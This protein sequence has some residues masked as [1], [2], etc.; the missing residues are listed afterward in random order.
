VSFCKVFVPHRCVVVT[1]ADKISLS[2][3]YTHM[4]GAAEC[5]CPASPSWGWQGCPSEY[6]SVALV[7]PQS[8]W[9]LALGSGEKTA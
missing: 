2:G 1:C 6:T 9:P 8:S 7:P 4:P 3:A 5:W